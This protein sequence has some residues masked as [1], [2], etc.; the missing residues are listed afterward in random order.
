MKATTPGTKAKKVTKPKTAKPATKK[1]TKPKTPT[2]KP[3]VKKATKPKVAKAKA[4]K[5]SLTLHLTVALLV[6]TTAVC[7]CTGSVLFCPA[8]PVLPYPMRPQRI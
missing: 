5:V 8:R 1:V 7:V 6:A 4:L 2:A 3:A